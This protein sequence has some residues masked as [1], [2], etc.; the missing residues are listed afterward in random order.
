MSLTGPWTLVLF[1]SLALLA[2]VAAVAFWNRLPRRRAVV[3]PT[4]TVM[5]VSCQL[6]ACLLVGV[7]LNNYGQ[8]YASWSD[9]FGNQS[10][11][12]A[13][14]IPTQQLAG[15]IVRQLR[16]RHHR[17]GASA[18]VS[19]PVPDAGQ[20]RASVALVYLPSA[21]FAPSYRSRVFPV[22]ELLDGYP[23]TPQSW[24]HS[25]KFQ[26]IADAEIRSGRAQPF[27]AVM[28][29]QNYLRRDGECLDVPGGAQVETTLTTNVRNVVLSS[30]R[31]SD[32]A[33]HWALMGYSTGGYCAVNLAMRHPQWYATGV[34]I[35]GYT[36]PFQDFQT[37]RIF[38]G[39]PA[40]RDA[41]DPLW[42]LRH[43]PVPPLSLLFFA[44]KP[45]R[46]AFADATTFARYVRAPMS[47]S[48]AVLPRGGHNFT[49]MGS[50]VPACVDWV[51]GHIGAPLAPGM[52][53]EGRSLSVVAPVPAPAEHRTRP[54]RLIL[55][56]SK[57]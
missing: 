4:R 27:I 51:S 56:A 20:A 22:V 5:L 47:M 10:G 15:S 46:S 25:L 24:V 7:L 12:S 31:A 6:T 55:Q 41:N 57:R 18:V 33:S 28:P 53:I 8:F 16:L 29:V 2:P 42:R 50:A 32:L 40:F 37:G 13:P 43:L 30:F 49:V 23:G 38:L 35:S 14:P 39:R 26:Q 9:L 21:Y 54:T 36:H 45:D 1:S 19:V 52:R 48:E 3:W 44:T 11:G 17:A 34:S